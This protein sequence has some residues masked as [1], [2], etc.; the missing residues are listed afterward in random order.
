V[1]LAHVAEAQ[2]RRR[3]LKM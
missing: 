2:I 3:E 1:T